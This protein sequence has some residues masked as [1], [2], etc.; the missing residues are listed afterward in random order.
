MTVKSFLK[1]VEIQTKAASVTPFMLGTV[2]ALYAFHEFKAVNFLLMF[3]S[4]ISFDM[5]T[6]AIN[7]YMDYKK[8]NKTHGYNYEKHNA[9]VRDNL[10]ESTVL[11]TIAVLLLIASASGFVLYLRTNLVVLLIGMMSFAVGILYLF[12][13]I[14][15]SRM[16]LGE[17][18][19][20][21][22]MGFVI[23]FLSVFIHVYDKNIAYVTYSDGIFNAWFDVFVVLK[24]FFISLPAIMGIANIMLANNICDIEDD[25]ENKRYTLPIYIGKEKAL[26][27]FKALYYI[28]YIDIVILVVLK[29]LPLL[30]LIVLLTFVPVNKNIREFY[31]VQTKKDTFPLSVKNFLI[32][33]VAEIISIGLGLLH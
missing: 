11:M 28:S 15:I 16:P 12:G 13:P 1:L 8:A 5:V 33:N 3:I 6:T 20:G 29:V 31:K 4:L 18:F 26:K 21:F 14:P 24:I 30:A 22:F 32:M 25:L 9:I 17:V 10:S 7:N 2:Y 19:S 23:V 27:L